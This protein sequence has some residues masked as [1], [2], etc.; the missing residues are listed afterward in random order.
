MK[1]LTFKV[2]FLVGLLIASGAACAMNYQI[3][4]SKTVD[5]VGVQ[6][7]Q[8][9]LALKEGF[10]SDITCLYGIAFMQIDNAYGK[11]TYAHVLAAKLTGRKLTRIDIDQATP[12]GS[13]FITL[14]EIN[15]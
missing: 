12:G 9:Y 7:A 15:D 2:A 6:S 14:V 4:D 11:A 8:F 5:K 3:F 10:R 13:C 1:T